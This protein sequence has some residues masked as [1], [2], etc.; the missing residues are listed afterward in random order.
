MNHLQVGRFAEYFVK[1]EFALHGFE[2]YT[3][4]VD[5]RGID[6]IARRD[7]GPF[8][9]VQVKS[10]R[11]LNYVFFLKDKF[12]LKADRLGAVVIL[13]DQEPPDLY[14]IQA[15]EWRNPDQLL[16]SNDYPEKASQPDF[17][18]N[19]SQKNMPALSRFAFD[20]VIRR[21]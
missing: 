1:M 15:T 20:Q 5:D 12:P 4:E 13:L 3:S 8:Y 18:I 16:R 7:G 14:L 11:T 21:L 2:V 6:F 9:E 10:T 19:L 17:G